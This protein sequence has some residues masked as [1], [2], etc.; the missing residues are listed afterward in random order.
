LTHNVS[1]RPKVV[2]SKVDSSSVSKVA[3]QKVFVGLSQDIKLQDRGDKNRINS[4]NID[5]D[6]EDKVTKLEKMG[7]NLKR[8]TIVDPYNDWITNHIDCYKLKFIDQDSEFKDKESTE[9]QE[10]DKDKEEIG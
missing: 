6:K 9:A 8:R 4:S 3:S 7:E 2:T 10:D 5:S 1:L